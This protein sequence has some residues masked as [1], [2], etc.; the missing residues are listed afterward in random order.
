M[1]LQTT[2]LLPAFSRYVSGLGTAGFRMA[3]IAGMLLTYELIYNTTADISL[4]SEA[5]ASPIHLPS[6][7]S[8]MVS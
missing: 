4:N 5:I 6:P 1:I 3:L 2:L 8:E 7:I